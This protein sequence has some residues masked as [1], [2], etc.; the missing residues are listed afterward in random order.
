MLVDG[1]ANPG[2]QTSEI[3]GA[4]LQ[5]L[6]WRRYEIE[7]YLVQPQAL[8]RFVEKQV[9]TGSTEHVADLLKHFE[10]TYPPA[11]LRAPLHDIPMLLG[12]KARTDLIPPA[13]DAAGLQG[14]PY[15]RYHEIAAVMLKDEI[16]PEVIE[17]LDAIKRAFNL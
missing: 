16:H 13:L 9:G 15:T 14:F 5:R 17:K 8:A 4:G 12:T 11:F 3:T 7:S 2:L 10:E 6:R 1:D